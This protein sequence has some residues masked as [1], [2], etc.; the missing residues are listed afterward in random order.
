M[1]GEC[2]GHKTAWLTDL[3]A[4]CVAYC[5]S[6]DTKPNICQVC[7]ISPGRG[8]MVGSWSLVWCSQPKTSRLFAGFFTQVTPH[9]STKTRAQRSAK[10]S[11]RRALCCS[12]CSAA[13]GPALQF[14]ENGAGEVTS[15][16][17]K[18]QPASPASCSCVKNEACYGDADTINHLASCASKKCARFT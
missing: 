1:Q 16:Q 10:R 2:Y 5:F 11:R 18:G 3:S 4:F 12:L 13:F 9:R 14:D 8:L 17:L 7:R 6:L 15:Q